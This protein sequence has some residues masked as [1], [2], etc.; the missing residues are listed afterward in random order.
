M[1]EISRTSSS[2][3]S[4]TYARLFLGERTP[5]EA[6]RHLTLGFIGRSAEGERTLVRI[7]RG[8]GIHVVKERDVTILHARRH[9]ILLDTPEG[10]DAYRSSVREDLGPEQIRRVAEGS[11]RH[12]KTA[13]FGFGRFQLS[14]LEEL[15]GGFIVPFFNDRKPLS[16]S[17][18][19]HTGN[20]NGQEQSPSTRPQIAIYTNEPEP[21]II[22]QLDS[23]CAKMVARVALT[24]N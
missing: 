10:L 21:V 8:S 1:S 11:Q 19:G 12:P 23:L 6:S 13:L 24:K 9:G 20:G 22:C 16:P 15:E 5:S 7:A 4:D 18:G 3:P 14:N 17:V 2:G